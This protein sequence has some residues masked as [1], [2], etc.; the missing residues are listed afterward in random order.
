MIPSP[1]MTVAVATVVAAAV[2]TAVM[3]IL[4]SAA[5]AAAA[6]GAVAPVGVAGGP[7]SP[8]RLLLGAVI[9]AAVAL[10][11]TARPMRRLQRHRLIAALL[12]SGLLAVAVGFVCGPFAL[13]L[14]D[15]S[16]IL[17]LKP[18]L[19][20]VVGLVGFVVGMQ[21][22]LDV[23]RAVP[24]LLWR[25]AAFDALLAGGLAAT[26][27][28]LVFRSWFVPAARD[29]PWLVMPISIVAAATIGWSPETRSVRVR[30]VP[31]SARLAV[32]VQACAGLLAA[33]SIVLLGGLS[34][35]VDWSGPAPVLVPSRALVDV[36]LALILA[37]AVGG[38]GA[39]LLGLAGRSEGAQITVVLGVVLLSAGLAADLSFSPLLTT[40]L[41]GAV[42]ANLR[43]LPLRRLEERLMRAE[44]PVA[45]ACGLLAGMLMDPRLG[46]FG[47]ALVGALLV[48]RLVVKP[49]LAGAAMRRFDSTAAQRSP[50]RL[51]TVR[52]APLA[53]PLAVAMVAADETPLSRVLLAVIVATGVLSDL[54]PLGLSGQ[55]RRS[56]RDPVTVAAASGAAT[57]SRGNAGASI[58]AR[59]AS[60]PRGQRALP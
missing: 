32:M 40:L 18:L 37:G 2:A 39:F 31:G 48:V 5:H 59:A 11:A 19:V 29:L 49:L 44:H 56:P 22:R 46:V 34:Q 58:A 33:I 3:A 25:W 12:G 4:P 60:G 55:R 23:L 45:T 20:G 47:L 38:G 8:W 14:V 51:A 28:L 30:L 57:D 7:P 21:L 10:F 6:P 43:F 26:A 52:Q 35:I 54:V 17:A 50:L 13:G 1:R 15:A 36:L 53:I 24:A 41:A 27:A 9:V 42:V 16:S